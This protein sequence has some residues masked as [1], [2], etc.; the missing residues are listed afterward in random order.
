MLLV[1]IEMQMKATERGPHTP[2]LPEQLKWGRVC[3]SGKQWGGTAW[4]IKWR[5]V[6]WGGKSV[7]C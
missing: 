6:M 4:S 5:I 2:H 1:S 7:Q 3:E